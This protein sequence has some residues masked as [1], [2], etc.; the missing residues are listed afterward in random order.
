MSTGSRADDLQLP[1]IH[2]CLFHFHMAIRPLWPFGRKV[3]GRLA[4]ELI[5]KLDLT[6]NGKYD[7]TGNKTCVQMIASVIF[8]NTDLDTTEP[9]IAFH[10]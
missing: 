7:Q 5:I 1:N 6:W 8:K 4:A 10:I 9:N 3:D 2:K